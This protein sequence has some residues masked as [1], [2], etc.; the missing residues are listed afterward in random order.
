[1]LKQEE[2]KD[3]KFEDL[4]EKQ[5]KMLKEIVLARIKQSKLPNNIRLSIG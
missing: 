4:T 2:D 3:K 1:M 5:K